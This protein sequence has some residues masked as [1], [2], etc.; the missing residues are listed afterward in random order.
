MAV[1]PAERRLS[2]IY[3]E[4][5]RRLQEASAVDFDDLLVLAVRLFRE[6]PEALERYRRRFRHVLVD[7][8][9]DTNAAQ[10]ELVRLLASEHRSV[11]V[12][13]DLDQC[14]VAGTRVTMARP[15]ARSRSRTWPSATKC[16]RATA[17]ATSAR[18]RCCVCTASRA[19]AGVSITLASGRQLVSTPE[20]MHFA[21][22]VTRSHAAAAHD[23]SD[24][25]A[26]SRLPRRNIAHVHEGTGEGGVRAGAALQR[27]R[28]RTRFGSSVPTRPMPRRALHEADAR[29]LATVSR[30]CR[31]RRARRRRADR[32]PGRRSGADRLGLFRAS[33]PRRPGMRCLADEDLS[34]D[35]P[36]HAAHGHTNAGVRGTASTAV[37]CPLRRSPG[38]QP[39]PPDLVVR[40]RRRR[41]RGRSSG[42]G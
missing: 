14:L 22:Y 8:F 17:A 30:R 27:R 26:R 3:T 16:C 38:Q 19:F 37:G 40:L 21:G 32:E 13:G 11:M 31:S 35:Y 20:H 29:R 23:V 36:H 39:V 10:W 24:V 33:T 34:F 6:F 4:Y 1:G 42:S 7:E 2:D 9:Q 15:H 18:L 5:Q 25:E 28:R 41:A 12:V